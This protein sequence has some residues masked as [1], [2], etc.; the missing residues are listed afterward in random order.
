MNTLAAIKEKVKM[1]KHQVAA[2]ANAAEEQ[3]LQAVKIAVDEELCGF[4]LFGNQEEITALAEKINLDITAPE[5]RI[6]HTETTEESAIAAVKSVHSNQAQILMKGNLSTKE[7]MTPVLSKEY[8]LRTGKVLSH[9]AL[10][11]IPNQNKLYFLTDAAMNISPA[12]EEKAAIIKNAVKV[13]HSIGIDIP[14][15]AAIAAVESVN[16]KMEATVDAAAL[17]QMQKRGQ[18]TGC[19]VDGPLAFDNAISKKAASHKGIHSDVAGAADI[20]LA[21]SIETGNALYKSFV[22]FADAKVAG[23]ISGAKA[24]IIVTSRSD[25][26]EDKVYSLT[27]ALISAK[28]F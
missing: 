9:V 6:E 17:T 21:P 25:S 12:M 2:V 1:E 8:G 3:V 22:Y 11:E 28:N 18:I 15:V 7:L 24:P 13:A 19:L 26:A 23:M 14:K 4:S 5:I 10:F 27:L 16:T 20:L